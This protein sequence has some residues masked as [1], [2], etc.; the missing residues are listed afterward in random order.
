MSA[1]ID[2]P[3]EQRDE[4][5]CFGSRCT[6]IVAD[7]RIADAEQA[8]AQSRRRLL[9]WH[10]QF[11][12][13]SAGSELT[14]LNEAPEDTVAVSPMMRRVVQ[15]AVDAAGA[16]G[17]LVDPTLVGEIE[18]AGYASHFDG[19]GLPLAVA[20]ALADDRA[21]GRPA[22]AGR[23]RSV[24][25]DRRTGSVM[26]PPGVRIDAGG[27][28]KGV[29][30]DELAAL[31]AGYD[32][33][34]VDCGGDMRLGGRRGLVRE[35]HVASPFDDSIL[36][37]F[38]LASGGVATSGIGRRSWLD[39]AGRPAHHLLDPAT[40]RPA[41]TGIVQVTALA[42]TATEAEALSKAALLSGP[43]RADQ[44]LVHGGAIVLDDGNFIVLERDAVPG[45]AY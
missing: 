20:L 26:R 28:A 3:V 38:T 22:A 27:I 33:F 12:R 36:H 6:V 29:F 13:F 16:T 34:V 14:R 1:T 9:E 11:S 10:G 43:E 31:L 44:V 24:R 39:S 45:T 5:A 8:A 25:T 15:A 21:P 32:A 19:D 40:G 42:P 4:F 7:A 37:T 17:G 30:A 35:V 2:I 23:W 18:R 41:F